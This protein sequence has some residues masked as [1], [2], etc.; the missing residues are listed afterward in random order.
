MM[1]QFCGAVW[2]ADFRCL[3]FCNLFSFAGAFI[4]FVL[5]VCW[6]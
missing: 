3:G 1:L 6:A 2:F 4:A 5:W